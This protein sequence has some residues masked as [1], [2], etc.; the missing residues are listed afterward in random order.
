MAPL[1]GAGWSGILAIASLDAERF[2]PGMGVDLLANL[3]ELLSLILKP[4][5][6]AA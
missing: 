1:S 3:A 2:R 5:I 4:W 6:K